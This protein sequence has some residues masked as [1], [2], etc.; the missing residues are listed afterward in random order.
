MSYYLP[1]TQK[2][3]PSETA[4]KNQ[5]LGIGK[6]A[7]KLVEQLQSLDSHA[8]RKLKLLLSPSVFQGRRKRATLLTNLNELIVSLD[9]EVRNAR[10]GRPNS[11]NASLIVLS[12]AYT[13]RQY[14]LIPTQSIVTTSASR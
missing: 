14:Q 3:P 10:R 1:S 2:A 5:I 9:D 11:P 12:V 7:E 6:T 8:N 13:M 4:V